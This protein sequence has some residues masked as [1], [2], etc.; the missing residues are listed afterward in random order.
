MPFFFIYPL[1]FT[2]HSLAYLAAFPRFFLAPHLSSNLN[3][4]PRVKTPKPSAYVITVYYVILESQ[5]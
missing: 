3:T 5:E 1:D 4:L 2:V